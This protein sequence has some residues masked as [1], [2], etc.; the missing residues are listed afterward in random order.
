MIK[1]TGEQERIL[2]LPP[3]N[4][5]QIKGV[6]GSGKTTIAIKRAKALLDSYEDLFQ[7]GEVAIFS[8][9]R[10]LSSYIKHVCE[11]ERFPVSDQVEPGYLYITNFHRWA[12]SF[13]K[14]RGIELN[15]TTNKEFYLKNILRDLRLKYPDNKI[16]DKSI[17][18]FDSEIHWMKGK[19]IF[20]RKEYLDTPR[21]G[22]GKTDRVT[23]QD[24]ESIWLVFNSY[25][26]ELKRRGQV[27]F[28]DFAP[29][30]LEQIEIGFSP[31]FTHI[32]IDEA[33]DLTKSQLLVLSKLVRDATNSITLIADAAQRIYQSGFSWKEVGINIRGGRTCEL[34][35]N[36]RSGGFIAKAA[37]SL[38][39][40]DDDS[41]DFTDIEI[42]N[43]DGVKPFLRGFVDDE[44][45]I[46]H[47]K[48]ICQKFMADHSGATACVLSTT[49]ERNSRVALQLKDAGIK[50]EI[51]NDKNKAPQL[52][53]DHVVVTS[54][55]TIKGM[56]FDLVILSDFTEGE[57]P[58]TWG[59]EEDDDGLH[60]SLQRRLL[61]TV[62]TRAKI[63][64]H[65]FYVKKPSL[66]LKEIDPECL[67][68]LI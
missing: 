47:I 14:S 61:Y 53:P 42:G 5:I 8:Y 24:R 16:L 36:Y 17:L 60:L 63:E 58:S 10:P 7:L 48:N 46:T 15:V 44:S 38:L 12:Y 9:G 34:K 55:Y 64:L 54:L 65:L 26:E 45:K 1:L 33:Q 51:I 37:A 39:K 52:K 22:R 50:I 18:F 68:I 40:N 56:E 2:A 28:D 67:Q 13:L 4:P 43:D 66:F 3:K 25:Q 59:K 62:M 11:E 31:P 29:L 21:I 41:E 23:K 30:V 35:K 57:M 49:N 6:A 20:T 27:E 32:V 19:L